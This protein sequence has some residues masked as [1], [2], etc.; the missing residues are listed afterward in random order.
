[1]QV[2]SPKSAE[3][4]SP[5]VIEV[6]RSAVTF[7]PE[8]VSPPEKV[9][10]ATPVQPAEVYARTWPAVPVKSEF[11]VVA[12]PMVHPEPPTTYPGVPA[13]VRVELSVMDDVATDCTAPDPVP[14]KSW[15]CVSEV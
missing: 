15:F 10:V 4:N 5:T 9:V 7:P 13:E 1:M 11:V 8:Y 2:N 6:P 12:T 14:Y 3:A